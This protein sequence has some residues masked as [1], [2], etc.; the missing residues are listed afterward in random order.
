VVGWA[1]FAAA[2]AVEVIGRLA[3]NPLLVGLRP[4][5]QDIADD[6]WL[7]RSGLAPAFDALVRHG[8]VFDALVL[9]RHLAPLLDVLKRHPGLPV[10]VDHLAK[11][12]IAAGILD[13]WRADIAAVAAFPSVSCKLS[14]MATEAQP[15][16]IA[17]DLKPFSD[18]ILT[19]FGPERVLWG[20][21]WPVVNL[22][23]GYN[24]W[25]TATNDLLKGFSP[26]QTK[27]ILGGNAARVYLTQRGK[28]P[29]KR[30]RHVEGP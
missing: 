13:P 21:D 17:A 3:A 14:G 5:V 30:S 8:L 7:S 26:A 27:A 6:A 18:H 28:K 22:A 2:D 11:P 10:V 23:G 12:H 20:S 16:W 19:Q 1:D 29:V 15:D 25:R 4:M 9:P 24:R